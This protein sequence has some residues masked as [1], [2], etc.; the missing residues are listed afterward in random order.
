MCEYNEK[1]LKLMLYT[2][3]Y[4]E[5]WLKI[6]AAYKINSHFYIGLR[7]LE[8]LKRHLCIAFNDTFTIFCYIIYLILNF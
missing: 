7:E 5:A 8:Y 3:V 2:I 4:S 1:D 6:S